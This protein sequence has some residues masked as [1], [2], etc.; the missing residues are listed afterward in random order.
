MTERFLITGGLGCI[1]AWAAHEL[2]AEGA[3]VVIADLGT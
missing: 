2:L 1:G 3:E